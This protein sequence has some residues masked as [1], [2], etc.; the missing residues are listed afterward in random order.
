MSKRKGQK[1]IGIRD[2]LALSGLFGLLL[3]L[4]FV[5]GIVIN[6]RPLS[7]FDLFR[8]TQLHQFGGFPGSVAIQYSLLAV[9]VLSAI[10]LALTLLL[11]RTNAKFAFGACLSLLLF[12]LIGVGQNR[13]LPQAGG[14]VIGT[15]MCACVA[16]FFIC[17]ACAVI[18]K[19]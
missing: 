2:T 6:D 13:H 17:V 1:A 14:F 10:G 15:A 19:R 8:S 16:L 7:A 11:H 9:P 4:F 18:R 12:G 5:P 3:L